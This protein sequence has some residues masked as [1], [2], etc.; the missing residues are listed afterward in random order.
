MDGLTL[1]TAAVVL[2]LAGGVWGVVADRI[3]TRWPEHD[4]EEGF[5]PGRRVGWRTVV[6]AAFGVAGLGLLP[7][8]VGAVSGAV[9][10]A[11][12]VAYDAFVSDVPPLVDAV[13]VAY[14]AALVLLLATD[15]DQRLMPDLITLPMIALAFVFAISGQNPFVG[16]AWPA[17]LAAAL[18]IPAVLYVPSLLFGAGAFGLGDVKLLV[19]VGLMSG[20]YRA[21]LGTVAG[22]VVAGIVIVV[23]LATRRVSLKT[24]IPFG[25][26]LILGAV[27]ALVLRPG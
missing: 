25:P 5:F 14:V 7:G 27:W 10:P 16:G 21:I 9:P 15:L 1:S 19:S 24:Y 6:V 4:P 22:I 11:G 8:A 20:A 23:L 18:V 2:G 3:A 26:F 17:A 13:L 12:A